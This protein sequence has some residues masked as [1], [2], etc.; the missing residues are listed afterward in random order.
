MRTV[1]K[2]RND[3]ERIWVRAN[4]V[5]Q[6][7]LAK[8][9]VGDAADAVA[10]MTHRAVTDFARRPRFSH[11]FA[12]LELKKDSKGQFLERLVV[13]DGKYEIVP[14][15]SQ[16]KQPFQYL[17]D[18]LRHS[19]V[20]TIVELGSG[21]GR[22]LFL[23]WK[24]LKQKLPDRNFEFHACELTD[25]GRALSKKI[26][27][28]SPEMNLS[29]HHFDYYNPDLSFLKKDRNVLF[30]SVASIEQ[31]P[32]LPLVL[33]NSITTFKPETMGV[34]FEPIGWQSDA[35]L[36]ADRYAREDKLKTKLGFAAT[37]LISGASRLLG[38]STGF[39]GI[40]LDRSDIGSS[41]SVSRNAAAWS[42]RKSYNRNMISLFT[43]LPIS[44]RIEMVKLAIHAFGDQPFNPA[45]ILHWKAK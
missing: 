30:I 24:E 21:Y 12:K 28:L 10:H 18:V 43:D 38:L 23:L 25:E 17:V 29:V 15:D 40:V 33:A 32:E 34:H 27:K 11:H 36:R 22:V 41:K 6:D 5:F 31:I 2:A 44:N 9:T 16:V 14:F 3:Y 8:G 37:N 7:F 35:A 45:T 26:H 1:D 4:K 39:P 42:M 13:V 19:N 20:D